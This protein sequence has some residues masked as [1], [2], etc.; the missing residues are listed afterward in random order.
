M[1]WSRAGI[2]C[3]RVTT[4]VRNWNILNVF[5]PLSKKTILPLSHRR[6]LAVHILSIT[7]GDIKSRKKSALVLAT[8]DICSENGPVL[9]DRESMLATAV[10]TGRNIGWLNGLF[11]LPNSPFPVSCGSMERQRGSIPLALSERKSPS[12]KKNGAF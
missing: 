2:I 12:G 1:A 7:T 10:L 9:H 5:L 4:A 6:L 3:A 11:A 8:S